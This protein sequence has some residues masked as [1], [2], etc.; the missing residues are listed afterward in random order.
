MHPMNYKNLVH[1]ERKLTRA[2]IPFERFI[3]HVDQVCRRFR[4]V[5]ERGPEKKRGGCSAG[6]RCLPFRELRR[7]GI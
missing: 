5:R 4:G 2:I 3:S 1:T 6:Q 7:R